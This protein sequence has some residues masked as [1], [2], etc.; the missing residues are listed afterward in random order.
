[1]LGSEVEMGRWHRA[2][3]VAVAPLVVV[4][5]DAVLMLGVDV[6]PVSAGVGCP[7]GTIVVSSTA[8][9]A[10]PGTLRTAL[11][12]A[13]T[14]VGGTICIDTTVVTSPI[15]LTSANPLPSYAG[16]G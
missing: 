1:M 14:N 2:C 9:T 12:T 8:D 10:T 15:E 11:G 13:I 5:L 3:A 6:S 16:A 7:G 4:A